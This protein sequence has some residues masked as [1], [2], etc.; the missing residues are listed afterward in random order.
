MKVR[1][2][3][4]DDDDL[5]REEY[6]IISETTKGIDVSS[7][8]LQ[9]VEDLEGMTTRDFDVAFIDW[10]IGERVGREAVELLAAPCHVYIV[11]GADNDF[12]LWNYCEVNGIERIKKPFHVDEIRERIRMA[13]K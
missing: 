4:L 1:V 10:Q 12:D 13:A 9:R 2:L 5:M 6:R 3:F 11:S 7:I 8:I